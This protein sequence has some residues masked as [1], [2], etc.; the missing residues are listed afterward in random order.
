[1]LWRCIYLCVLLLSTSYCITFLLSHRTKRTCK[2]RTVNYQW[3]SPTVMATHPLFAGL[4]ESHVPTWQR[5]WGSSRFSLT[6]IQG[7]L[8]PHRLRLQS[9]STLPGEFIMPLP[10]HSCIE[11]VLQSPFISLWPKSSQYYHTDLGERWIKP[12]ST[13]MSMQQDFCHGIMSVISDLLEISRGN[14]DKMIEALTDN[15]CEMK[16]A[17]VLEALEPILED[18][19]QHSYF[20][21]NKGLTSLFFTIIAH[22][23]R[24]SWILSWQSPEICANMCKWSGWFKQNLL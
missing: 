16:T 5:S 12:K 11:W 10:H 8:S 3:R 13:D 2:Q 22:T 21:F 18:A 4:L 19:F 6:G 1:M 17:Q 7:K 20:G 9:R 23:L 15:I 24:N 14:V